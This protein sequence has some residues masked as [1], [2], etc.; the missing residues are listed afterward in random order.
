M[1]V[2]QRGA[3]GSERAVECDGDRAEIAKLRATCRRQAWA[4]E[5]I[6]RVLTNL[7]TGVAAL[8]AE[9]AELRA[10]E[11]RAR[12]LRSAADVGWAPDAGE[13]VEARVPLDARAP[14]AARS[15]VGRVLGERVAAVVLER[16]KLVMSELVTNSVRHSG[17]GA[18]A[19]VV[20]RVCPVPEGFWLEVEDSGHD[21]AVARTA[22]NPEAGGGYGLL[23]V[24]ALSE[25]W[26]LERRAQGGTR[27]WAHLSDT[28][29]RA[30]RDFGDAMQARGERLGD[31]RTAEVHV[32]PEPR[33]ATWGVYVDA[34]PAPLSEHTSETEA[35]S[36]ARAHVRGDD[37][38]CVVVHDRYH[39]T[40]PRPP[41]KQN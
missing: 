1:Q 34:V 7:R 9:N 17:G 10:L 18:G 29:P 28:T 19:A 39:R 6:M 11:S 5:T 22:V 20:V 35:E 36:A 2:E 8:K 24:D 15:V 25:Q 33:A 37:G 23:L 12:D 3:A 30:S 40:H 14:G 32:I 4:I 13:C 27:A 41:A 16:A 21:G 26:G 31:P 38:G